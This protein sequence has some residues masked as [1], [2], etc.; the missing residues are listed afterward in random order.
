M[1]LSAASEGCSVGGMSNQGQPSAVSVGVSVALGVCCLVGVLRG[2]Q[3]APSAVPAVVAPIPEPVRSAPSIPSEPAP[4]PRPPTTE[5]IIYSAVGHA[6]TAPTPSDV[7]AFNSLLAADGVSLRNI[8][9][10]DQTTNRRAIRDALRA[11]TRRQR[12]I[13]A[14][15]R[16]AA[17]RQALSAMCGN[18][19]PSVG[20]WDGELIGSEQYVQRTAHD[21][22]SIDVENCTQP[23][24]T[25]QLCW[26]SVCD[27]RGRNAFGAMVLNRLR[28]SVGR[29]N[30]ILGTENV[31]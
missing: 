19:P 15:V 1:W 7:L 17:E 18:S 10:P 20:G 14:D 22:E 2:N 12:D 13:R 23:V 25:R 31:N 26:T 9:E 6:A 16:A 8:P 3:P 29:N 28:F 21:P 11:V 5:E 30:S 24:L 27:V 4:P